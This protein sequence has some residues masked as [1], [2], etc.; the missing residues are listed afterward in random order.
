VQV[1][2]L[3]H[4]RE[5]LKRVADLVATTSHEARS[6]GLGILRRGD[7]GFVS[8]RLATSSI[9][10]PITSRRRA[11]IGTARPVERTN[12]SERGSSF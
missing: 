8:G 5:D 3:P 6:T 2:A 10:L 11:I 9:P 1:A 4:V 12:A 7:S